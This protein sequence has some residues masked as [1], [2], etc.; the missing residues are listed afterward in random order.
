VRQAAHQ[1]RVG[2][3]DAFFREDTLLQEF[4]E[5]GPARLSALKAE[6]ADP[7]ALAA[8]PEGTQFLESKPDAV[9]ERMSMIDILNS[10]AAKD[11]GA[12]DAMVELALAPIDTSLS[13]TAKK[14]LVGEKYDIL[15]RLAQLDRQL[16]VDT[17]ARLDNPKLMS[18][19]REALIAGLAEAGA[20]QDEV[21]RLTQHL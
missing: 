1:Y 5:A 9:L 20:T 11:T 16:A 2:R 13:D 8:L 21:K 12:R 19:L 3:F 14:A 7:A 6:L 17:Y 10:A 18:L 15:F 4:A